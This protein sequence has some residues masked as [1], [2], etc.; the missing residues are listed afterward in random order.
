MKTI[1]QVYA[2]LRRKNRQNYLMLFI[3]NFIS[4]LLIT[5][6][7][8]IMQSHTIQTMLPEGGDSRKQ[9]T[10]IFI[11]ALF[12]C[13]VFTGYASTL[14]FRSKSHEIGIY[15]ALGVKK[16]II[17]RL[18][19]SDLALVSVISVLAGVLLG[20]PLAAGIWQLFRLFVVD[21]TD[22]IFKPDI[23]GFIWPLV[24]SVFCTIMLFFMGWRFI[25]RSNIVDIIN[26]QH[27]SEPIRDAKKWYGIVGV[28]LMVFGAG[29]A[30]LLP[31]VFANLG[32]T[33]PFWTNLLFVLVAIGLYLLLV[34]L[35]VRGFGSKKRYYKNIITRS[36]M[37]FQGRQTV[38]N[39]CVIAVLTA[40]TYFAM[41]YTPMQLGPSMVGFAARH[42]DNAFHYRADETNIPNQTDINQLASEEGVVLNDYI[43]TEFVNLATDG[44]DREWTEDG[45]Y[46]N[47]YHE[48]YAENSF[49]SESA[50]TAITNTEIK[51][52][53]G[54]FAYVTRTGY[55]HTP[56]D[57]FEEMTRFTNPDT[58]KT[59]SV[60]FHDEVHYD[61]LN[62]YIILNDEDYAT[63]TTGLGNEW[64]ETWVQFNV[65]NVEDSYTFAT[66]LRNA[67]IDGSSEKSAVYEN[68]DRIERMNAHAAGIEY[69][70]DT[71]P[72]LQ[73][74]Y[75][76]RES[77]Q[78]NQYWK[79][80]PLFRVAD[81]QNYVM[82]T[83]VFL[84]L[85]I[86][87]AVIC[88]A[89]VIVIAYTRC[90][91]IAIA[92][93]QI[94]DDLRHLGAKHDYLYHSV[95]GQVAKVFLI[96]ATIGTIGIYGFFL[97]LMYSNSGGIDKGELVALAI[98]TGLIIVISL[99][100]WGIYRITLKKVSRM[101][102]VQAQR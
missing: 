38:L 53:S 72:D 24:F 64:R 37:R 56:Y 3:C 22:M 100:L 18:M 1:Q 98:N 23:S 11:L 47:E 83:S 44:Y 20:F 96:P 10:M 42:V 70:G 58:L 89:A 90:L 78:F 7:S 60:T 91:T 39:M 34:F 87:M 35:V 33:V 94:Y 84:M 76:A 54:Q 17:S 36:M 67:I 25:R 102:G 31:G 85:F 43:E 92:N 59:L 95:K 41:F 69:R 46:G 27:K 30:I 13:I 6:F 82:N 74:S 12:G 80:T 19:F 40:A 57:Y 93:Q 16:P 32:Y 86:F 52:P 63:I 68:Y 14:F 49:L 88:M 55:N 28:L 48:I 73:V 71:E 29:G 26:E 65:D 51:I 5:S 99:I 77:S 4:V 81:Q 75:D 21:S 62:K 101:L 79:Y 2:A 61:M 45:R 8:V 50:F 66:R 15:M 9:M 97:L